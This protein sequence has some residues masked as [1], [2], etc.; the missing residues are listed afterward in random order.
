MSLSSFITEVKDEAVEI[1]QDVVAAMKTGL[2]YVDN[3]LVTDIGPELMAA[4]T[5][6]LEL[7]GE[8]ALTSLL[9][10]AAPAPAVPPVSTP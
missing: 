8:A 9:G 10:T 4:F 2:N 6:A 3:V 7:V 5:K 1:E